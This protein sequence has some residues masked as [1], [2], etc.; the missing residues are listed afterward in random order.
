MVKREELTEDQKAFALEN[1]DKSNSYKIARQLQVP[2]S[3]V[4][5]YLRKFG[6]V[7]NNLPKVRRTNGNYARGNYFDVDAYAKN[8]FI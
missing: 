7:G 1:I 3:R 2:R 5:I 6:K 4:Y 8:Y